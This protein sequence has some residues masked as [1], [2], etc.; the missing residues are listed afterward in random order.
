MPNPSNGN[1]TIVY[2]LPS[3][4]RVTV[5]VRDMTGRVVAQMNE[6]VRAAGKNMLTLNTESFGAG[7]Y[8]YTVT[9]GSNS[10]TKQLMV[11]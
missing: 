6:G 3:A 8:T 4:E 10:L 1:T 5:T 9:A 2:N 7:I 11:K